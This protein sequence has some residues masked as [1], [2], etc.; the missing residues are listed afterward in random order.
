MRNIIRPTFMPFILF[1]HMA[2]S[3]QHSH[4]VT[5]PIGENLKLEIQKILSDPVQVDLKFVRGSKTHKIAEFNGTKLVTHD[6]Q[7]QNRLEMSSNGLQLLIKNMTLRDSG[8]YTVQVT[9]EDHQINYKTFDVKVYV[10][11]PVPTIQNETAASDIC[12]VTLRCFTSNTASLDYTWKYRHYGSEYQPYNTGDTIQMSLHK[13]ILDNKVLCTVCISADCKNVSFTIKP[14][15]EV[16]I[17]VPTIQNEIAASDICNVTFRCFTSNT[18]S[19]DYTWKYRHY[20]SEY[21]PYNTGNTIQISLHKNILDNKVLC[22]VCIS[23]DCKNVS[24]TIKPCQEGNK[25]H[26]WVLIIALVFSI[27]LSIAIIIICKKEKL[28]SAAWIF[29]KKEEIKLC[30][31]EQETN[32]PH[33]EKCTDPKQEEPFTVPD[34][35]VKYSQFNFIQ[36]HKEKQECKEPLQCT[37]QDDNMAD[38]EDCELSSTSPALEDS[39]KA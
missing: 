31:P 1:L 34:K 21:Q 10:P 13:D 23:A 14:C 3:E 7:F 30:I 22:T 32:W 37:E 25:R 15:Q 5:C 11:V 29:Y 33:Q 26:H 8:N 28:S 20:G 17:P 27:V 16:L 2:T 36:I 18:V 24:S 12:N 4:P 38:M 6:S 39:E 35:T 19:L 9:F